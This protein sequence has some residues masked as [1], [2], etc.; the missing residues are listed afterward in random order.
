MPHQVEAVFPMAD[1]ILGCKFKNGAILL[2]DLKS[3]AKTR[4]FFSL[5]VEQPELFCKMAVA[6]G[7][8]GVIWNED[9]DLSCDELWQNG[10]PEWNEDKLVTVEIEVEVKLIR[11]LE[12]ILH[13]YGLAPEDW[14]VMALE[15]L[16]CP[17]TKDLAAKWLCQEKQAILRRK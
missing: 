1:S 10:W 9:F 3:V 4:S 6:P 11:K 15:Y 12:E 2:Y 5:L 13:P 8:Y 14:I 16:V 17:A 7:G